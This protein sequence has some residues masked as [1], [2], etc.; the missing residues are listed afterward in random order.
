MGLK[1]IILKEF[2]HI[3]RDYRTLVILFL[4]PLIMIVLFGYAMSLEL[5][6]VRLVV[7]D[8]D[9]SSVSRDLIRGFRGS[10]FFSLRDVRLGNSLELFRRR[11]AEAV[12]TIPENFGG[13]LF[14]GE[15]AHLD[16]DID[17]ADANRGLIVR[18]YISSV[19]R[20][21]P[22]AGGNSDPSAAELVPAFL[23]N[24]E[25]SGAYFFVPA[26]TALIVIM[27]AALLTSLT[28]TRE[29]EQGTFELL[30]LSPVHSWEIILGKVVPYLLLALLIA[31][32]IVLLGSL[33]FQVPV[34]GSITALV[35]YL[36]IYCLT[37]LSFGIL[38]S[39]VADSQQAAML[40]ALIATLLPTLFLSGFMFQLE[41]MPRPLQLISFFVPA[42]YF[43]VI[44]RGLMLKGNSVGE[45]LV[46]GTAL[47]G[48]SCVFIVLAIHR[49]RAY[50]EA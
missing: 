28:I 18:Q 44:L 34:R 35:V 11:E 41:A 37:G 49:F 50:L 23:Y 32:L 22:S 12:L 20:S 1:A 46:P 5:G 25:R 2:K 3:L 14:R 19:I 6:S 29:K 43:L 26:L 38:I 30:R 8:R 24:Q 40:I 7:D 15:T 39:T 33:L 45:L 10:S 42:R 31:G 27:V 36:L 21:S 9:D 16:I 47:V 4:L 48:F 17:A 13:D